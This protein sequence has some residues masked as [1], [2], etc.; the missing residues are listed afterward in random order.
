MDRKSDESDSE[1]CYN[2]YGTSSESDDSSSIP[3][4]SPDTGEILDVVL[5]RFFFLSVEEL[6]TESLIP[7]IK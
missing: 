5:I 1:S 2:S 4:T 3:P 6:N 7:E